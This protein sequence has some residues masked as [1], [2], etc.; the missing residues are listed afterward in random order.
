[1]QIYFCNG[2]L[3]GHEYSIKGGND[4]MELLAFRLSKRR[5]TAIR[6]QTNKNQIP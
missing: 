5:L 6:K 4:T 1:M 3:D 2:S